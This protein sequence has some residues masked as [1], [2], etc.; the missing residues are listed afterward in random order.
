MVSPMGAQASPNPLAGSMRGRSAAVFS[1]RKTSVQAVVLLRG[2]LLAGMVM[3][4]SGNGSGPTGRG[5]GCKGWS[6]S[7]SYFIP[8]LRPTYTPSLAAAGKKSLGLLAAAGDSIGT[9]RWEERTDQTVSAE[10]EMEVEMVASAGRAA[11]QA[12]RAYY[13]RKRE[14]LNAWSEERRG[15]DLCERCR[16]ARKV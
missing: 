10:T 12:A 16:R 8:S 5:M 4:T 9:T 11:S 7:S 1:D 2:V 14:A 6:A 15:R 13:E 3:T